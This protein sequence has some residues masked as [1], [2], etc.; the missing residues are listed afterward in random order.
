MSPLRALTLLGLLVTCGPAVAQPI[1]LPTVEQWAN[2]LTKSPDAKVRGQAA[3]ALGRLGPK[4][5]EAVPA[6]TAALDD[7]S[8]SVRLLA[9]EALGRLGPVAGSAVP[10]LVRGLKPDRQLDPAI[11][12]AMRRANIEALVGI[13]EPAV[14][15]VAELLAAETALDQ[16]AAAQILARIGPPTKAA[17]PAVERAFWDSKNPVVRAWSAAALV[18]VGADPK[19]PLDF[20]R[21]TLSAR[22]EIGLEAGA[23][24]GTIGPAAM[25]ILMDALTGKDPTAADAADNGLRRLGTAVV[26]PMAKL[27]ASDDRKLRRLAIRVLRHLDPAGL[28]KAI[29]VLVAELRRA[30]DETWEE[31]GKA[32]ANAEAAAVPALLDVVR[33]DC[34]K[35]RLVATY[36]LCRILGDDIAPAMA[37][38]IARTVVPALVEELGVKDDQWREEAVHFL[39]RFGP[40]AA[41]A[42]PAL[43]KIAAK[44]PSPGVRGEALRAVGDA[45]VSSDEVVRAVLAGLSDKSKRARYGAMWACASLGPAAKDAVPRLVELVGTD[46]G[47]NPEPAVFALGRIG[48]SARAAAPKLLEVLKDDDVERATAAAIALL[49][50]GAEEKSA[51]GTIAKALRADEPA[52]CY[53]T[54][55]AL[56]ILRSAG[57]PLVPVLN[58]IAADPKAERGLQNQA[59]ELVKQFD[60]GSDHKE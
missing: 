58:E 60:P 21:Q 42:V 5:K 26:E 9:T 40:R 24:L 30:D 50:I 34:G 54:I 35:V 3:E 33:K 12:V 45:G 27:L 25:P 14:A 59:R 28:E 55:D 51:V 37:D 16:M 22:G 32:L 49:Q 6:L 47:E 46:L 57:K 4:A 38:D 44:D 18:R 1:P 8:A 23:A 56:G 11:R 52:I 41:P 31:A 2:A 43:L 48:P 7:E 39:G 20:L 36:P 17:R 10:Q 29:P 13:G 19:A 15:G 53:R